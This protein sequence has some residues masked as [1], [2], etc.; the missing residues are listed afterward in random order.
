M[1]LPD[2]SGVVETFWVPLFGIIVLGSIALGALVFVIYF[3]IVVISE[4]F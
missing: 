1:V 3:L 4:F 2:L